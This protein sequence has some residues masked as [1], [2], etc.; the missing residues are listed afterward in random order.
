MQVP[1]EHQVRDLAHLPGKA[2]FNGQHRAVAVPLRHRLIG[3]LKG[4]VGDHNPVREDALG[5]DIGKGP[6]HA[7]VGDPRS[8]QQPVLIPL[9]YGHGV[10]QKLHIIGPQLRVRDQLRR[11]VHQARL[12]L[13]VLHSQPVSLLVGGDL[14]GGGHPLQKQVRHLPVDAEDLISCLL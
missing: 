4:S 8:L 5:R 2:V 10:L 12:P 6:L 1:G 3:L 14:S 11:P 9:G 7:A 13:R